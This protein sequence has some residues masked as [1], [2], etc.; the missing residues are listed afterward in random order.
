MR[1]LEGA[2]AKLHVP[3]HGAVRE[4][5]AMFD[6]EEDALFIGNEVERS[7][8]VTHVVVKVEDRFRLTLA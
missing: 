2:I 8:G 4:V 6:K 3:M 7:T 1:N 5:Y